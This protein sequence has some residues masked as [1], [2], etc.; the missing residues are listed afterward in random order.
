M[1]T[2]APEA[3]ARPGVDERDE[4]RG[5]ESETVGSVRLAENIARG[6]SPRGL[7]CRELCRELC[8]QSSGQS[9]RQRSVAAEGRLGIARIKRE[10]IR[11]C[12]AHP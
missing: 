12:G 2:D 10:R 7:L 9:S 6:T 1:T 4:K 11:K 5:L 8:R 3:L